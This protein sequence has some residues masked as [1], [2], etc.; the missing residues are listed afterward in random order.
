MAHSNFDEVTPWKTLPLDPA[1]AILLYCR[2]VGIATTKYIIFH[3]HQRFSLAQQATPLT[4]IVSDN[5]YANTS[6]FINLYIP[7]C[8]LCRG[9]SVNSA[10][11]SGNIFR[12][13]STVW[14]KNYP[15]FDSDRTSNLCS[16]HGVQSLFFL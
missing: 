3:I 4:E 12:I 9:S 1:M 6:S 5:V 16:G 15:R 11:M 14:F 10:Y 8:R 7:W 2:E 13:V